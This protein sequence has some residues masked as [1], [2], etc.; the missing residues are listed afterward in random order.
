MDCHTFQPSL[1]HRRP[2][3]VYPSR[4]VILGA[5][6]FVGRHTAQALAGKTE[7]VLLTRKEV[8]LLQSSASEK[9]AAVLR[10]G[11]TLVVTSA[12]APCKSAEMLM[13]NMQMIEQVCKAITLQK[14]SHLIYISSDA[15]YQDSMERL[16]EQSPALPD[17][18]H[19]C[20]HRVREVA[21]QNSYEGPFSIIR[22]TL[23]YGFDDP[24]N[25]YGP[26]QFIRK[27]LAHE[28]ISLFGKGEELRDHIA[29]EDVAEIIRRVIVHQSEGIVNAVTGKEISFRSIAQLVQ[30]IVDP[31]L[32][33][34]KNPRKGPMPHNGFR[35]FDPQGLE[36]AFPD[37]K[38]R[39]I[40]EGLSS[41]QKWV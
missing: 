41:F 2:E 39:S 34:Q 26:N 36:T 15:V 1:N 16:N 19:G 31:S 27:A 9:L 8:D 12:L 28:A 20:M 13:E 4:V 35:A 25:G 32:S 40:Q 10:E 21:L 29:V 23:I 33:I 7:L 14:P 24:H 38:C 37:F 3:P 18:Y 6:G 22:P 5:G 17:S 11:D 30:K